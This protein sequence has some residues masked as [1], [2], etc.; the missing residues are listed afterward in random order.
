HRTPAIGTLRHRPMART[1]WISRVSLQHT[2]RAWAPRR[3]G[4]RP[5]RGW[6][7]AS[8]RTGNNSV[9]TAADPIEARTRRRALFRRHGSLVR[10]TSDLDIAE[11]A[12]FVE[13]A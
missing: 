7:G 12:G 11:V 3:H 10:L 9:N 8:I 5:S 2:R 4:Q 6:S 13:R 1:R